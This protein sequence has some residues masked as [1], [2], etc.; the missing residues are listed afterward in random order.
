LSTITSRN[1]TQKPSFTAAAST[2]VNERTSLAGFVKELGR[3]AFP[4]HWSFLLGEIAQKEKNRNSQNKKLT[5][6][7]IRKKETK[8]K[9]RNQKE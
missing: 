8:K 2:Y 3:K 6:R 5:N 1:D 9:R 7:T 4:D